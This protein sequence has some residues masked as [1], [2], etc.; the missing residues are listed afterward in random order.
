[1]AEKLGLVSAMLVVSEKS[2]IDLTLVSITTSKLRD[3]T[4]ESRRRCVSSVSR[5]EVEEVTTKPCIALSDTPSEAASIVLS[6]SM[7][8]DVGSFSVSKEKEVLIMAASLPVGKEEGTDDGMCVGCDDG[9][10]L[11]NGVGRGIGRGVGCADGSKV[12]NALGWGVGCPVG[13]G[14]GNGDGCSIGRDDG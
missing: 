8:L 7:L 13:S 12:G 3:Q 5:L 9:S 2:D 6:V 11:G 14:E 1:M 10:K 4:T